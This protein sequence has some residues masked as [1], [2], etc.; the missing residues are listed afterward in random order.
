MSFISITSLYNISVSFF[1]ETL[2]RSLTAQEKKIAALAATVFSCLAVGSLAYRYIYLKRVTHLKRK[3]ERLVDEGEQLYQEKD[4]VNSLIKLKEA[5]SIDPKNVRALK[6]CG[7]NLSKQGRPNE[8]IDMFEAAA[9]I[10]PLDVISQIFYASDLYELKSDNLRGNEYVAKAKAILEKVLE[11]ESENS[12]AL[13]FYGHML[14]EE[15]KNLIERS[16]S[17][18]EKIFKKEDREMLAKPEIPYAL[19]GYI[20]ALHANGETAK[21]S[22]RAKRAEELLACMP[23]ASV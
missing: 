11:M 2:I 5:L 12:I 21:T 3:V 16:I 18:F 20:E 1:K 6:C 17:A 13:S 10:E 7:K 22:A 15:G 8:A 19:Q 4:Y 9:K 14:L 23:E